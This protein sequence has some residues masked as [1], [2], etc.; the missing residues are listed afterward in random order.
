MDEIALRSNLG[1]TIRVTTTVTNTQS[2]LPRRNRDAGADSSESE[3]GLKGEDKWG[4]DMNTHIIEDIAY[5]TTIEAGM[6]V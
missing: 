1:K 3:R 2:S 4:V 5:R 6:A